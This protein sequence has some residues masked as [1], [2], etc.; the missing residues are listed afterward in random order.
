MEEVPCYQLWERLWLPFCLMEQWEM[1]SAETDSGLHNKQREP[2][3]ALFLSNMPYSFWKA[4]FFLI[5]FFLQRVYFPLPG[6][7]SFTSPGHSVN[8]YDPKWWVNLFFSSFSWPLISLSRQSGRSLLVCRA[9]KDQLLAP[10]SS[11]G[12]SPLESTDLASTY[13]SPWQFSLLSSPH[14]P[15]DAISY[16]S[17]GCPLWTSCCFHVI[18]HQNCRFPWLAL[19]KWTFSSSVEL[20]SVKELCSQFLYEEQVP[21][22]IKFNFENLT[23][24]TTYHSIGPNQPDCPPGLEHIAISSFGHQMN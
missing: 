3:A 2:S 11:A 16:E 4:N 24:E 6:N 20:H 8:H 17:I 15:A 19:P 5:F 7:G 12:V 1:S 22:R 9:L 10:C 13:L 18:T 14:F 21:C 23:L